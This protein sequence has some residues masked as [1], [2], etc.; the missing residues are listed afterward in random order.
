[1]RV[2]ITIYRISDIK[3][4]HSILEKKNLSNVYDY[5]TYIIITC[6]NS[7]IAITSIKSPLHLRNTYPLRVIAKSDLVRICD[8]DILCDNSSQS[9]C[10][11]LS[12]S[13]I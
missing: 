6:D 3:T 5:L 4:S 7:V 2:F 9:L 11:I 8:N 10:S 1:M 12:R 13:Y